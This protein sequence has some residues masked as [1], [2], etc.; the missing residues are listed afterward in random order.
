[1]YDDVMNCSGYT[2]TCKLWIGKYLGYRDHDGLNQGKN[3]KKENAFSDKYR[4]F[5][6]GA[7]AY[8]CKKFGQVKYNFKLGI[9]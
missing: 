1:M 8:L 6:N 7:K 5:L 2:G 3:N 4:F 9:F